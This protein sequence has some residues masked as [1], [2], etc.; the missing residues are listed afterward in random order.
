MRTP[1]VDRPL[2]MTQFKALGQSKANTTQSLETNKP[3]EEISTKAKRVASTKKDIAEKTE[4]AVSD[5]ASKTP[6]LK[7][8]TTSARSDLPTEAATE[9]AKQVS[10]SLIKDSIS[11]VSEAKPIDELVT[12]AKVSK[13]P[14]IFFIGGLELFSASY[15]GMK[16]MAE[17]IPG[18]RYYSWDQKEDMIREIQRRHPQA[19]VAL[20]GHSYG[21]D[22]AVKI[23][24]EL[25]S[26]ENGFRAVN[27]LVTMDA[28]GRGN[29][30]IPQN[31]RSTINFF[32]EQDPLFN[33]GP[34]V[35]RNIN[36]TQ[37]INELRPEDHT[38]MDDSKDIQLKIVEA[39]SG[40]V[41]PMPMAV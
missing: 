21:A 38:D 34:K 33:D 18:A 35:A 28:V 5:I 27:L 36:R 22:T 7:F 31:V 12:A 10:S 14:A 3:I 11:A 26:L 25:N 40:L 4:Q 37:V 16:D 29:D 41:N 6:E 30:I 1:T 24:E 32:G 13:R 20:V 9:V 8:P 39:L 19:P 15:G 23:A 17:K 2:S